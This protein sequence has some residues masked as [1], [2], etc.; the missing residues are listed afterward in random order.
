MK[1]VEIV[2]IVEDIESRLESLSEAKLGL[3][4][5]M[6]T[7]GETTFD[8][9]NHIDYLVEFVDSYSDENALIISESIDCGKVL[10]I[11]LDSVRN[12]TTDT[13]AFIA[14]A[15]EAVGNI[16]INLLEEDEN[17]SSVTLLSVVT[18]T[19]TEMLGEDAVEKMPAEMVFDIAEA[20][21]NLDVSDDSANM[22]LVSLVGEISSKLKTAITE[23]SI[24]LDTDDY[25][26]ETLSEFL[27]DYEDTAD[28]LNEMSQVTDTILAESTNEDAA[29]LLGKAKGATIM[30]EGKM[31]Q[32]APGD[33]KC[34][35]SK[36]KKAKTY[37]RTHSMPGGTKPQDFNTDALSGKLGKHVKLA[38]KAFKS[39]HGKE[40][41]KDYIQYVLVP[42]IIKRMRIKNKKLTAKMQTKK[43]G[44]K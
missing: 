8:V 7:E 36:A 33:L 25:D 1:F 34:M 39:K 18:N 13:K 2:E 9:E 15:A 37:Y 19:L 16:D 5:A 30:L 11:V 43:A 17:T 28:L 6:F 41:L 26:G 14:E 10:N 3:L 35:Q 31:Q 4:E 32:C 23:G 24:D 27:D 29:R 40:P 44:M 22:N 20:A 38:I 12:N 42:G 21:K